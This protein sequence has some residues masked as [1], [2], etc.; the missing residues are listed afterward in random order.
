MAGGG[1]GL[2]DERDLGAELLL[3]HPRRS[4]AAPRAEARAVGA[5]FIP[6]LLP[7]YHNSGGS[8]WGTVDERRG[9]RVYLR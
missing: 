5:A 8:S 6:Y 9:K 3:V 1:R 7:I 4:R 2:V